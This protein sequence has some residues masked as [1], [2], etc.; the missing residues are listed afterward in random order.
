MN[1]STNKKRVLVIQ[2][3]H[4]A[5]MAMLEARDDV[6]I[7]VVNSLDEDEI[8][9]AAKDVHGMTVRGAKI[10]KKIMDQAP[11]LMV[12]SRH[13]VG[14]DAVDLNELNSRDIPLCIAIHSNMVSVAEQAMSFLLTLAKEVH[15]YDP[16]TRKNDW[17]ERYPVRG[18]DVEDKNLLIVGF[19]RI[20][21]RV[22]KRANG[23]DMKVFAYDP[24]VD[25]AVIRA[26]GA[27]PVSDYNAVLGDMDAV[28]VHCMKT[29]ETTNMFSDAQFKAMKSSAIIVNCARGGIIDEAALYTALT[30]GEIRS[31]GLDVLLDEPSSA[32]HPLFTISPE[33]L[34]LSPHI[35]G[36]TVESM[37]RMATQTVDNVLRVF[38]GRPDPECVVNGQVLKA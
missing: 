17:A 9:A 3:L 37:E 28:A 34:I 16:I 26:G 32:D 15:F 1:T 8:A 30:T 14:Y 11:D 13:G 19:G 31:A 24:Y 23:F 35:A 38:D 2:Q 6:E 18:M 21:S 25:D 12:V 29:A 10:T 7:V 33:K 22:A 4:P 36:V 20:G 5:G 27:E